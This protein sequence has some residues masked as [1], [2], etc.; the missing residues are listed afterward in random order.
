LGP[1]QTRERYKIEVMV[2]TH[3]NGYANY[4]PISNIDPGKESEDLD[5]GRG[6]TLGDRECVEKGINHFKMRA[7]N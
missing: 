7:P 3:V 6:V 1:P 2:E 5:W 4:I